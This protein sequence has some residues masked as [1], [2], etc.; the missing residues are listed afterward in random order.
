MTIAV[1]TRPSLRLADVQPLDLPAGIEVEAE[2]VGKSP[3]CSEWKLP[4]TSSPSG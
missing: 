3:H 4:T 1:C 2:V